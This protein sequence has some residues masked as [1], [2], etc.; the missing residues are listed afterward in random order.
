MWCGEVYRGVPRA[1]TLPVR[2]AGHLQYGPPKITGNIEAFLSAL[3]LQKKA[4]RFRF[5]GHGTPR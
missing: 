3:L 4:D 5:A 2:L 1:T